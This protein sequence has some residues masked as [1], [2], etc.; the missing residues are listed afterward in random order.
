[1]HCIFS[2]FWCAENKGIHNIL[3]SKYYQYFKNC[4]YVLAIESIWEDSPA[5]GTGH[6]SI[7]RFT[8]KSDNLNPGFRNIWKIKQVGANI[9]RM[10]V[11]IVRV[12]YSDAHLKA[13]IVKLGVVVYNTQ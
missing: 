7:S 6:D 4:E 8:Q 10:A 13:V 9:F 3:I 1:M 2:A 5:F 11:Y 12:Y